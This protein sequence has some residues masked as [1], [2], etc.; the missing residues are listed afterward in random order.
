MI[1]GLYTSAAGM[2]PLPYSQELVT[3]N[4]SNVNTSG[5][6]QDRSFIRD[7]ISADLYL[8]QNQLASTGA[9]PGLAN[10]DPPAFRASVGN[11]SRVVE[12]RTD[13]SQGGMEITGNDYHLA[14]EGEGFFTVRTPQGTQYTRNGQFAI[15]STGTLVTEEGFEVLGASGPINVQGGK[16][17]VQQ[18]GDVYVN[19]I[20]RGRL[21]I[22]SLNNPNTLSKTDAGRF[23]PQ[24]GVNMRVSGNFKVR[25]GVLEQANAE[26]IDQLVRLIEIERM[27]EFG[28]RAIRMQDETLQQAVTQVGKI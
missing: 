24:T 9:S 21:N 1:K 27:F 15:S 11:S 7:L 18:N 12:Y 28:Q 17:A 22:A 5:Y 26:P 14:L 10:I 4:L 3:N 16:M 23:V 19:N 13:F 20:L 2:L 6:K 8:N 25:Q